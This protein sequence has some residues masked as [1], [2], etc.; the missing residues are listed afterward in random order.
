MM[1]KQ[2]AGKEEASEM[3]RHPLLAMEQLGFKSTSRKPSSH[4]A[5]QNG[6][7]GASD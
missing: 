5:S 6:S 7:S 1:K 3:V 4:T 2:A